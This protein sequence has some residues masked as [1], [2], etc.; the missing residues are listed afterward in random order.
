MI[1]QIVVPPS[2]ALLVRRRRGPHRRGIRPTVAA[3]A[4]CLAD[5]A[6]APVR[7]PLLETGLVEAVATR[8]LGQLLAER[9]VLEAHD[10]RA[11]CEAHAVVCAVIAVRPSGQCD[12]DGARGRAP[13]DAR[14]GK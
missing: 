13:E 9:K 6:D 10:A 2:D 7:E 8:E 3:R 5:G 1:H 4:H 11:L 14:D 12:Q